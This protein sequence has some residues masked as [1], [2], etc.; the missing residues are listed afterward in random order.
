MALVQHEESVYVTCSDALDD[1]GYVLSLQSSGNAHKCT[2]TELPIGIALTSTKDPITGTAQS[3]QKVAIVR[4]GV[5]YVKLDDANSSI[6]P[7]DLVGVSSTAGYV[8]KLTVDT[9]DAESLWSSLR[10]AVGIALE[11]KSAN[12]GGKIKVLLLLGGV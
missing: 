12:A 1:Y 10:K 6:S 2:N 7:G 11:S 8:D 4:R 5:A 3:D 9:T